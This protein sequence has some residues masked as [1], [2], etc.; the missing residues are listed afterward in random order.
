MWIPNTPAHLTE[1]LVEPPPGRAED[2]AAPAG[3]LLKLIK[4]GGIEELAGRR[5]QRT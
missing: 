4:V 2:L 3:L 5:P 1:G